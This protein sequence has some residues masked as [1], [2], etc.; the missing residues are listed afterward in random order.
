MKLKNR[1][2]P[3]MLVFGAVAFSSC[4]KND[5][6]ESAKPTFDQGML[7]HV[8]VDSAEVTSYKF[9]GKQL[10]QVNHYNT[11]TGEV[12]SFDR[13]EYDN[14]SRIVKSTV[15]GKG[16]AVLS[17]QLYTYGDKGELSKSNTTY[18]VGGKAE[19][20]T[21]ATYAYDAANKLSKKSVYEGTE[22]EGRLKSYT[23]YEALPNGNYGQ[24]R[25]YVLDAKGA[26]KLYS[27]TTHSYDANPNP[28]HAFA[29]PGSAST[30]NNLVKTTVE[31]HSNKKSFTTSYAYKYD[32]SGYPISQTVTLPDGKS[33]T[34]NFL[35]GK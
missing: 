6:E 19:Y 33:Q 12:E 1:F 13:Y 9:A 20:Q 11:E 28:F 22:Q 23:T 14:K 24:E 34:F 35:Y 31:V 8:M 25:Q 27:T 16:Q 26:T 15:Y 10:N 3:A 18:F 4:E 7:S 17:E 5:N 21:Y 2:L 32:E 29:E 30:P